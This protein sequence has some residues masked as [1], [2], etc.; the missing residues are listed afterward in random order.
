[1]NM[2]R[3]WWI[4]VVVVLVGGAVF[5]FVRSKNSK[6]EP[7]FTTQPV[8]KGDVVQRVTATGTLSATVTVTVGAQISGRIT[9]LPVDFN[10]QVKKGSVL[11]KIDPD[12]FNA[13]LAQSKANE[14]AAMANI[15]K[16]KATA[17]DAERQLKRA[18]ELADQKLVAQADLDTAQANFDIAQAGIE[19]AEAAGAQAR[20][21]REQAQVNLTYTTITSPIDGVIISRAVEVGQTV[22]SS[23]QTP[24]L[25]TIAEDLK[26][27]KIDTSVA[28]AD[29]GKLKEGTDVTFA[30]D[31]FPQR[32]FAG[33]VRQIRNA[34]TITSNVVTY[35][36]VI[37]V[38]NSELLL[39]PGMTANVTFVVQEADGVLRV[40]N[41]A[42]RFKLETMGKMDG[43]PPPP[44]GSRVVTV[45]RDGKP[46]RTVISTGITDGS[47]T[48]VVSGLQA[49]ELVVTDKI[50]AAG[51]G[52]SRGGGGAPA[53]G[54]PRMF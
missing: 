1:M 7:Q 10:S 34:A 32:K 43:V 46:E 14:R 25:F 15:S 39:R 48:E 38:E 3:A 40:P 36:A 6:P 52:K 8:S 22:A 31:A 18:K 2:K 23:Y 37:D 9:D 27:M 16:A 44:A 51:A 50:G 13:A 11:A 42:L 21:Q 30:V 53:G 17:A 5:F 35:D 41:A 28:E 54:P 4:I 19:A 24:T 20:A 45:L 33:K 49:G 29:V 12:L 26:R 47:F